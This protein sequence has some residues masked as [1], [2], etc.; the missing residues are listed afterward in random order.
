[1]NTADLDTKKAKLGAEQKRITGKVEA[2]MKKARREVAW[3]YTEEYGRLKA[4]MNRVAGKLE[5]VEREKG[6]GEYW[7]RQCRLF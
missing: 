6:D 5:A 1:M 3:N 4:E 7:E 2:L